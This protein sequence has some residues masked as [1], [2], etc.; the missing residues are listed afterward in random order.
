[1]ILARITAI[2]INYENYF[3]VVLNAAPQIIY[4][5]QNNLYHVRQRYQL[6]QL[7]VTK[8]KQLIW[9][10]NWSYQIWRRPQT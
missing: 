10:L 7:Q 3:N 5:G 4:Q 2:L 8:I 6:L 9:L 1:M